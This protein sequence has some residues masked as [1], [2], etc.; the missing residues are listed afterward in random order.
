MRNLYCSG[1]SK[2]H[3]VQIPWELYTS[4]LNPCFTCLIETRWPKADSGS[5]SPRARM[6]GVGGM[7]CGRLGHCGWVS[8]ADADPAPPLAPAGAARE[9]AHRMNASGA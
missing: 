7:V 2:S 1:S 5:T 8:V 9:C 6:S 4:V 3:G